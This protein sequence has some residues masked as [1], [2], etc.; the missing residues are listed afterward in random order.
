MDEVYRNSFLFEDKDTVQL[1]Y[2]SKLNL[3]LT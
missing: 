3:N 2:A 1:D